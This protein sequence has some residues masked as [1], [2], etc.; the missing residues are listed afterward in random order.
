MLTTLLLLS[1][2]FFSA[3]GEK[4]KCKVTDKQC[5]L[6]LSNSVFEK[7]FEADN[8]QNVD[9][10]YIEFMEGNFLDLKIKFRNISMTGYNTCKVFDLYWDIEQFLFNFEL[11]CSRISINGQYEISGPAVTTEEKG[12]YTINTKSYKLMTNTT[13]ELVQ[14]V[15]NKTVFHVKNFNAKVSPLE[16]V[17]LHFT[18]LYNGQEIP[19]A[20]FLTQEHWR[21][22]IYTL[23]DNFAT[24]CFRNLFL[25]LNK[26]FTTL[27]L[28][29]YLE[30]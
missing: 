28:E 19:S 8:N 18:N 23:Q 17:A 29:E 1:C 26:L 16:K 30:L 11:Y 12:K 6:L 15:G 14:T 4:E 10:M 22:I 13:F 7:V 24:I 9:P 20:K 25:A 27:P 3:S 2:A 21:N 5:I